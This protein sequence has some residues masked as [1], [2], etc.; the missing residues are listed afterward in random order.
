VSKEE[1]TAADN[2]AKEEPGAGEGGWGPEVRLQGR[3]YL[4]G[5]RQQDG[6]LARRTPTSHPS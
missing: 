2:A 4:G 3:G 6:W 1:M 5:C